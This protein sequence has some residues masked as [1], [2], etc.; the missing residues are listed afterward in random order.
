MD[1]QDGY[2]YILMFLLSLAPYCFS[3]GLWFRLGLGEKNEWSTL[4][5]FRKD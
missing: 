3:R 4:L 1:D 5:P 2:F